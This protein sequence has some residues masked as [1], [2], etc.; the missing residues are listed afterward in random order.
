M[1]RLKRAYEPAESTDGW[2]V[3]VERLWPRGVTKERLQLDEWVKDVAPTS[4]LRRWFAHDPARW[5]EFQRR[6]L[7]ELRANPDGWKPLLARSRRG[8]VTLVYAAR[9]T[10]HSGALVLKTFLEKHA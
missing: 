2:R 10:E 3:L 8:R 7:V 1:I 9:D 4:E 5:S 6:Y